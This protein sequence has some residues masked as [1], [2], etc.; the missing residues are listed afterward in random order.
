MAQNKL[1]VVI[2]ATLENISVCINTAPDGCEWLDQQGIVKPRHR[3]IVTEGALMGGLL[4]QGISS[5]F[6]N[7]Q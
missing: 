3:K 1:S 2:L 7:Y 6:F 5:D 4:D